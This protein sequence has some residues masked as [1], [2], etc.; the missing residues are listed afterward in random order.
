MAELEQRFRETKVYSCGEVGF[1]GPSSSMRMKFVGTTN[2]DDASAML[3]ELIER[4]GKLERR[5]VILDL[6]EASPWFSGDVRRMLSERSKLVQADKQAVIVTNPV[7]RML[8]KTML[9]WLGPRRQVQLVQNVEEARA[10][11]AG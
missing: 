2:A 4:L 6:S 1:D 3:T 9:V 7:V 10:Y 8:A 11:L 5:L